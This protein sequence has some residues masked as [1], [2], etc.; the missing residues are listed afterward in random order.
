[1][2]I[3]MTDAPRRTGNM[4]TVLKY[5]QDNANTVMTTGDVAAGLGIPSSTA[6]TCLT[7][8]SAEPSA[9]IERVGARGS[10]ICRSGKRVRPAEP[11]VTA[12]IWERLEY[13]TSDGD[14]V[15]KGDDEL[16]YVVRPLKVMK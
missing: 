15:A 8:L 1:M 6:S 12:T 5:M 16:L 9:N 13:T 11:V 2:E 10:W 14:I 7:R 3:T 4:W